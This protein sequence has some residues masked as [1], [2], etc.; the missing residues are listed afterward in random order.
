MTL[1]VIVFIY[2]AIESLSYQSEG[3]LHYW[4]TLVHTSSIAI[5]AALCMT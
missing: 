5:L 2:A 4:S 1:L 3:V